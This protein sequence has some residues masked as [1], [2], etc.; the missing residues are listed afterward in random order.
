MLFLGLLVSVA[1]GRWIRYASAEALAQVPLR[2]GAT[3]PD[4]AIGGA[5]GRHFLWKVEA[6][7]ASAYLL[8]SLHFGSPELYPLP[9]PVTAAYAESSAL[10]VEANIQGLR[11]AAAMAPLL[12][13]G[14]YQD[15]ST[16]QDHLPP[17]LWQRL[18]VAADELGIPAALLA[19][20]RPWLASFTLTALALQRAGFSEDLGLDLHFMNVANGHKPILELESV[21]GQFALLQNLPDGDQ[22]DM[23]RQA[24]DELE[25][26]PAYFRSMLQ[27]WERGD[28]AAMQQLMTEGLEQGATQERLY[29]RLVTQRNA[30]MAD[31]LATLLEQ[32]GTYFVVVGAGHLVGPESVV[33]LLEARGY[34]VRRF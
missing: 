20:Q 24:L 33:D 6:G 23:L 1:E 19:V 5:G 15:G 14:L 7:T 17:D 29:Q 10:V 32:G 25:Q 28:T 13:A 27:A 3:A 12:A 30:S 21:E 34:R 4:A 22:V 26:G 11:D 8:G 16:L 2:T 18:G 9:E 31:R